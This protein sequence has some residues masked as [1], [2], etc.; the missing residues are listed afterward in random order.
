[1]TS[2]RRTEKQIALTNPLSTRFAVAPCSFNRAAS[3]LSA[4]DYV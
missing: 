3:A 1:M 4:A 2:T